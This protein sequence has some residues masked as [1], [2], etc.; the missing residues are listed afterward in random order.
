MIGS[1]FTEVPRTWSDAESATQAVR[2]ERNLKIKS[3]TTFLLHSDYF[4]NLHVFVA[5]ASQIPTI[6]DVV[7]IQL[8]HDVLVV[9]ELCTKHIR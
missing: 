2:D 6:N 7:F 4:Q 1:S 9:Q 5:L 3:I 8:F